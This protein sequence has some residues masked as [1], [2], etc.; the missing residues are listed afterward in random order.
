MSVFRDI[1]RAARLDLHDHLQVPAYYQR[2][3]GAAVQFC[4]VRVWIAFGKIGT[5]KGSRIYPGEMENE[6]DR[7]RFRLAQIPRVENGATVSIE[8]GE[9]YRVN[10]TLAIDD[11]F[12]T[13]EVIRLPSS[14][15]LQV[16]GPTGRA[17]FDF[18]CGENAAYAAA[19]AA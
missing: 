5:V 6:N 2:A 7:I 8:F 11:D 3:P 15:N 4:N 1:R 16:P 19:L 9:A 10:N 14:A 18:G 13:A 17:M 12:Q